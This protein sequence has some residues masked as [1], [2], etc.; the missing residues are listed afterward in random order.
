MN[1]NIAMGSETFE[2]SLINSV[3]TSTNQIG[4]CLSCNVRFRVSG[5]FELGV[6]GVE[7]A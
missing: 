7:A 1:S 3:L 6:F 4:A 5:Q 2:Y